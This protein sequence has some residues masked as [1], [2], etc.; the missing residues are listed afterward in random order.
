MSLS[1]VIDSS[2]D[3][4][5]TALVSDKKIIASET[6]EDGYATELLVSSISSL[7]TSA[8]CHPKE[9]KRLVVALGPGSFTGVRSSLSTALGFAFANAELKIIGVPVLLARALSSQAEGLVVP[10]ITAN[11]SE[12]FYACYR[13]RSDRVEEVHSV[14]FIE[15]EMLE[16]EVQKKA[17]EVDRSEIQFVDGN[18]DKLSSIDVINGLVTASSLGFEC[19]QMNW[20]DFISS[21]IEPI[22]G[23][24]VR[25]KT[26]EER[27]L[28][29]TNIR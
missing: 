22:Y 14:D 7:L 16:G 1:L 10:Y 21:P 18:L 5:I 27:K 4:I 6:S 11:K 8:D 23:K 2:A 17:E 25:A 19:V 26:I 3:S 28:K 29:K 24:S 12:V 15:S 13:V 9:I 20:L